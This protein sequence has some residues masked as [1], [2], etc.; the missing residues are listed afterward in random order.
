[1][2]DL[3]CTMKT[4]KI[5]G[6]RWFPAALAVLLAGSAALAGTP[7][8]SGWTYQGKLN[9]AGSP[10]NDTADFEFTLW[11]ADINGNMIGSVVEANDVDVIDGLFTVDLDF[12]A[13]AFNGDARWLEIDVRSPAGDG[14]FTT[15][16]P[17][18]P[19]TAAP[20]AL[21]LPGLRTEQGSNSPNVIGGHSANSVAARMGAATIAGG[22]KASEPNL[23]TSY[24]GTIG[25]GLGNT[26]G[27]IA[28]VGGG[29]LN[30]ATPGSGAGR[31]SVVAQPATAMN[32]AT[33]AVTARGV[34]RVILGL[35]R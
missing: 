13:E 1:M 35:L 10:L 29:F 6:S 12:G 33:A 25:G 8:G 7:V 28:T 19:L 14:V 24:G 31:G 27:N 20:Y 30:T 15:L 34:P 4:R 2:N 32:T 18:Q 17:R 26:S 11:D 22:G 3:K 23:I 16:D 5:T 9:V 21:A